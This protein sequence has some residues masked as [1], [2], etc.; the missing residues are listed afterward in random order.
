MIRIDPI[1]RVLV[2]TRNRFIK[3]LFLLFL[4]FLATISVNA[5]QDPMYTQY[6]NSMLT[7]NPAYA[8]S[9]GMLNIMAISRNQWVGLKDPPTT[10]ALMLNTP[11]VGLNMGLG[12]S[13]LQDKTGPVKQTAVYADYSYMIRFKESTLALGIKG[14][15]S[16]Y[17]ANLSTLNTGDESQ[18]DPAIEDINRNFMPNVGIGIFY[19]SDIYYLGFSVPQLIE[20]VIDKT[21]TVTKQ[22]N[23]QNINY[24]LLGGY[25]INLNSILKIKPNFD[26]RVIVNSPL[27]LDLGS[28]LIL[29]DRFRFGLA[30]R[31]NAS[32]STII[33]IQ[34]SDQLTVGYAYDLNTNDIVRYNSGSHELLL[35]FDFNFGRGRI[36]SPRYF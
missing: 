35:N 20:N 10:Q 16:F 30:Y 5:Q 17:N 18:Y 11:L 6:H 2:L 7:I 31:V 25:V 21:S 9:R 23:K 28:E 27:S 22:V 33:Q 12:L 1:D 24:F 29:L 36:K 19:S 32:V 3:S 15:V 8:G 34:L 4:L 14:G 13:F 26:A